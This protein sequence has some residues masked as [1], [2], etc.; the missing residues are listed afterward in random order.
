MR[1]EVEVYG[2]VLR[3]TIGPEDSEFEYMESDRLH[4]ADATH[5]GMFD[6]PAFPSLDW[7]DDEERRKRGL[8]MGHGQQR[9]PRAGEGDRGGFGFFPKG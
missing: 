6:D 4:V 8:D 5:A 1:F 7:G 9:Q 2:V 3:I